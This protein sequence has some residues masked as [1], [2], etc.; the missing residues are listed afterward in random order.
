MEPSHCLCHF[1]V[2][3]LAVIEAV[4]KMGVA[5]QPQGEWMSKLDVQEEKGRLLLKEMGQLG[6]CGEVCRT[7]EGRGSMRFMSCCSTG[8]LSGPYYQSPNLHPAV[9]LA[10][11]EIIGEHD[12]VSAHCN[13]PTADCMEQPSNTWPSFLFPQHSG[14]GRG[15]ICRAQKPRTVQQLAV[16]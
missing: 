14:H 15:T 16:L 5:W 13:I 9:E 1:Q 11:E 6:E 7:G 8:C 3:E 12:T 4:E 2:D 10:A